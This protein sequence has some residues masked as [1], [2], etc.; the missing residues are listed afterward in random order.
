MPM[1]DGWWKRQGPLK[2]RKRMT[3]AELKAAGLCSRC[4]KADRAGGFSTCNAC[5]EMVRASQARTK[6]DGSGANPKGRP[7]SFAQF[8]RETY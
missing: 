4:R 8:E 5:R 3:A 2:N 7:R 6:R 1:N